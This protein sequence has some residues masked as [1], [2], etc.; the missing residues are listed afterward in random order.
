[1]VRLL[2]E[3]MYLH[4]MQAMTR[5][6]ERYRPSATVKGD[7]SVFFRHLTVRKLKRAS[8]RDTLANDDLRFSHTLSTGRSHYNHAKRWTLVATRN[9][10]ICAFCRWTRQATTLFLLD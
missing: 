2:Y 4:F 5:E 8:R 10:R 3:A 6:T 9:F 7:P 1:M